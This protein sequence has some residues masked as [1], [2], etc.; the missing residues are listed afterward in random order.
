MV[1]RFL[2][3]RSIHQLPA[4]SPPGSIWGFKDESLTASAAR[5]VLIGSGKDSMH[6]IF[7]RCNKFSSRISRSYLPGDGTPLPSPPGF[8]MRT[9]FV[10][11]SMMVKAPFDAI[12]VRWAT[13]R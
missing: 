4:F 7:H 2:P 8:S 6:V 12:R 1:I 3:S 10:L 11:N 13:L 5:K 9:V